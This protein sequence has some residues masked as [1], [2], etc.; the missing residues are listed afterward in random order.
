MTNMIGL[1]PQDI[2]KVE[3]I[4]GIHLVNDFEIG[5]QDRTIELE[6]CSR[7]S[8]RG[9]FGLASMPNHDCLANTTH[10]FSTV[11]EAQCSILKFFTLF[12]KRNL[13]CIC[14]YSTIWFRCNPLI[15]LCNTG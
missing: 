9:L 13:H 1:D 7:D 15:L 5:L 3:A 6:D 10:T 2:P 11:D 14:N 4:L 12:V 8:I